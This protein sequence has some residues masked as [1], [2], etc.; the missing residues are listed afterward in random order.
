M[1]GL[2]SS[3]LPRPVLAAVEPD[4]EAPAEPARSTG[5]GL[6]LSIVK[7]LVEALGGTVSVMSVEAAGSRFRVELP[8]VLAE[9]P[10]VVA[11][12]S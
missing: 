12:A 8:C 11:Q 1:T 5:V 9:S 2:M 3:P 6:G 4:H 10:A 7:Q